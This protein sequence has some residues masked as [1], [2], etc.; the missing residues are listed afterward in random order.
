MGALLFLFFFVPTSGAQQ[1]RCKSVP[2]VPSI[3]G[4]RPECWNSI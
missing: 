1:G 4:I 3:P 2:V